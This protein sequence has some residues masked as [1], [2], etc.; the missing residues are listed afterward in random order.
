[1]HAGRTVFSQ[2][3]EFAPQHEFRRSVA[4]YEAAYRLRRFSCW[5]QF[6][7]FA[8]AQLTYCESLR[9]VEACLRAAPS[10]CH[11]GIRA[12]SLARSTLAD[13]GERRDWRV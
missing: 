8:F 10:L 4:R 11:L 12:H 7:C 9:D 1:M 2:L 13:A 5:V 6:L 3:M